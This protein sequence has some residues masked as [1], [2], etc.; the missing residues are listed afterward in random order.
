M[1]HQGRRYRIVVALDDSEYAG[2][3][4]EH[5]LD[6]AV[7][8]DASDLHFARIVDDERDIESA[9]QQLARVVADAYEMYLHATGDRRGRLHVRA[10]DTV[11]ELARLA[12]D[13][14]ADLLVVGRFRTHSRKGSL[15]GGIVEVSPCPVLAVGLTERVVGVVQCPSCAAVREATD[16][17]SLFCHAHTGDPRMR[18]SAL[19]SWTSG[20]FHGRMW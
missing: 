9:S 8:H 10:G 2:I 3:V 17:E 20:T 18:S 14:D 11:E 5:A 6:Q 19:L 15:A 1:N 16:A 4:L 7:R 12:A 13:L